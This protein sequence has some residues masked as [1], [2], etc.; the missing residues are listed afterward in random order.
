MSQRHSHSAGPSSNRETQSAARSA[1]ASQVA[2]ASARQ[3]SGASAP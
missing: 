2:I 1:C 3:A